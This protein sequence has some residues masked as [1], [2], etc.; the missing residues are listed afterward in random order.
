MKLQTNIGLKPEKHQ[1]GYNS[2]LLLL[3]SCFVENIGEKLKYYKFQTVQNPFGILFHP[4]TIENLIT[5]AI[6]SKKYTKES[7][8]LHNERWYCFDAHSEVSANTPEELLQRLNMGLQ[9]TREQIKKA[10]HIVI[11][12]GTAWV[13]SVVETQKVVANCHKVPQKQFSKRV[14]SVKEIQ[15][16]L[17][18]ITHHI[19]SINKEATLIFTI[20]PVRHLKDG[21]V[22]NQQSKA[23]LFT[24]LH[25]HLE[26]VGCYFPSYEIMMDELRDYRFYKEDM[27]H[28]NTTA[29]S[30]IWEKFTSVWM[31]EDVQKVMD[32]VNVVQKGLSH[33]PFN[34]D[35]QEHKTFL[36]ALK[37]K[38][39]YLEETYTF[40][41]FTQ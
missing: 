31:A 34:K 16:S 26:N 41:K 32:K 13:Y 22:E 18:R 19:K 30:Y 37:K 29:I 2:K 33:R 12:L 11:T 23:H 1:I 4:V 27:V 28:P 3:G 17:E 6:T 35:S 10:S 36:E 40:M 9:H 38:K 24:A 21:F 8:F 15:D 25:A 39:T 14:L 5:R 7:I 20:S